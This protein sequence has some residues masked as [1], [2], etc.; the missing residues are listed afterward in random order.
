[1]DTSIPYH[2]VIEISAISKW[3]PGQ[4]Y[5]LRVATIE[6]HYLIQTNNVYTRDQWIHSI[7]WKKHKFKSERVLRNAIRQEVLIKEI[8]SLIDMSLSTPVED[9]EIYSYPLELISEILQKHALPKPIHEEII[10]SLSPLLE[11][12]HPS[13]EICDFFSKHCIDSPRSHIVI[14]MF[15]PV[16]QRILKHN[17]DF[18]KYPRMRLFVQDYLM[19]LISQNDGLKTVQNF[20]RIMHSTSSQCPFSRVLSNF[21]AV[22]LAAVH[23]CFEQ[24]K[25]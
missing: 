24:R 22:C 1:M 3:E 16:V 11:K 20:V 13:P 9:T 25:S 5:C 10:V 6:C 14:E 23:G 19:A 15:T 18:G 7:I 12:N 17:G 2:T 8:R 21:V 4:K